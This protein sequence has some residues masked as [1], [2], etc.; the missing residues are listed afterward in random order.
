MCGTK[1][2]P[3]ANEFGCGLTTTS[4]L[5]LGY[6]EYVTNKQIPNLVDVLSAM[7][8]FPHESGLCLLID[9]KDRESSPFDSWPLTGSRNGSF[10]IG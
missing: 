5:H 6:E 2:I 4:R 9:G 1:L 7:S 3:L 8:S 10:N